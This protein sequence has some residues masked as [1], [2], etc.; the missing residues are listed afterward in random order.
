MIWELFLIIAITALIF[1]TITDL[2]KREV[3]NWLSYSL[4]GIGIGIRLLYSLIYKE[5]YVILYGIIGLIVTIIFANIMYY[6]RQWG[7]GDCK[8]LMG[9][10]ALFGNYQIVIFNPNINL[11][12][13]LLLILNIFV[14]GSIY[15]MFYGIYLAIKNYT[16]FKQRWKKQK[17]TIMLTGMAIGLILIGISFILDDIIKY[18]GITLGI[19]IMILSLILSILKNVEDSCM[20][21]TVNINQLTEGDWIAKDVKIKNKIIISRKVFGLNQDHIKKLKQY[22]I[23]KVIIKEGMPFVPGFLFGFI[24]TIIFGNIIF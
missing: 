16:K 23:K 18:F 11:P 20:F 14:I 12:F 21:K 13:L 3:P 19:V 24:I 4:I 22:Q 9:L 6:T 7:G 2:K 10:G 5:Y 17:H 1:A 15:G 8:L